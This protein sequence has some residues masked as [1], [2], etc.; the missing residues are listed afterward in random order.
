MKTIV[1]CVCAMLI[2]AATGRAQ[3]QPESPNLIACTND[4]GTVEL[5]YAASSLSGDPQ[6]SLTIDGQQL[7]PPTIRPIPEDLLRVATEDTVF[8]TFVHALDAT[9]TPLDEPTAVYG[10]FV[11]SV[12]VEPS[13]RVTF[14]SILLTGS[15]GGLLPPGDPAQRLEQAIAVTCEGRVVAF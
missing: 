6:F 2:V 12:T 5:E 9:R 15:I 10:F 8:G 3:E 7:F 13:Q 11:P 1:L 4:R 14:Q